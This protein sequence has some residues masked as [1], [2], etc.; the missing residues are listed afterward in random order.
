MDEN[1]HADVVVVGAGPAGLAA[2]ALAAEGGVR[3]LVLDQGHRPG[4]QVWRHL[5]T[6][7]G[8][9]RFWIDR[10]SRA[11]ASRIAGASVV[12]APAPVSPPT[13]RQS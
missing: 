13:S 2:G 12:D 10:L 6:P 7:T 11:G 9:A 5:A 4:G 1:L 3:V 8:A